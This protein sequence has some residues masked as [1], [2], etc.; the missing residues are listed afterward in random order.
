MKNAWK[1]TICEMN[2][3]FESFSKLYTVTIHRKADLSDFWNWRCRVLPYKASH[4]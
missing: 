2:A 1:Q 3:I 4:G